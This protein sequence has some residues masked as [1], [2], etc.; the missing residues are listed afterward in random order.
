MGTLPSCRSHPKKKLS[1][2]PCLFSLCCLPQ[3]PL[4]G[5]LLWLHPQAAHPTLPVP[6]LLG[7]PCWLHQ[8][9]ALHTPPSLPNRCNPSPPPLCSPHHLPPT[10]GTSHAAHL[11]HCWK[12]S[13]VPKCSMS[14]P[15]PICAPPAACLLHQANPMLPISP[16]AGVPPWLVHPN[17][18]VLYQCNFLCYVG[19]GSF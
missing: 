18:T 8:Q 5:S 13:V 10:S 6:P 9:L 11:P 16:T 19:G 12:L 17:A 3:P 2:A 4:L 15:L 7:A 1:P 14:S